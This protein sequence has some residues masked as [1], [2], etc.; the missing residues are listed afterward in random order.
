MV[1]D[2]WVRGWVGRNRRVKAGDATRLGLGLEILREGRGIAS[3]R[4]QRVEIKIVGV[5]VLG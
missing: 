2:G 1:E 5:P 4:V 3:A